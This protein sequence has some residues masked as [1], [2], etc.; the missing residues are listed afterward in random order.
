M[1]IE[2]IVEGKDIEPIVLKVINGERINK[3]EGVELYKKA[4][5][6]ILGYLA[7]LVRERKNGDKV[8]FNKNLHIE[9]T[10]KCVYA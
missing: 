9:P 2:K 6:S 1:I 7:N 3:A 5:L 4:D 10:N 8:Y